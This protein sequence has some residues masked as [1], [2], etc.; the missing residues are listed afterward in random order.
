M[1]PSSVVQ[2]SAALMFAGRAA[3]G[4][5]ATLPTMVFKFP[6]HAHTLVVSL[7]GGFLVCTNEVPAVSL[8][9]GTH[10]HLF[11][12]VGQLLFNVEF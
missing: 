4:S 3:S 2:S 7:G 11:T 5:V 6:M 12:S 10:A 1:A 9:V 8:V